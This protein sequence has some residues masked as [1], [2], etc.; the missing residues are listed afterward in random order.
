MQDVAIIGSGPAG[1]SAALYTTRAGLETIVYSGATRGGLPTTT[2]KV[3]NYLGLPG[4]EGADMAQLFL[5][6][7]EDL[8]AK[9]L[10]DVVDTIRRNE[11]GT[12]TV[13]LS[14]GNSYDFR[15]VIFAAGSVPRKLGVPGEELP[16]V[17]WCSTCDGSFFAGD[18]VA[19]VGGGESAVEEALYLSN[20]ASK[21]TVLVRGN[22]FRAN[23][24]AVEKLL[25]Q[26]NVSVRYNTSVLEIQGEDGVESLLLSDGSVLPVYGIFEAIG[27][28]PQSHVAH[29]HSEL[30]ADGYIRESRVEGFFI[31]GDIT[32][33]DYRQIAV[34]VGDGA[35]AAMD[36]I[37]WLQMR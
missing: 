7:A 5:K 17:S 20:L 18:D 37:K 22:D 32:N 29:D 14:S 13:R 19:V 23:R 11:D 1:L 15:S 2:E 27:Q 25:E 34:A 36:S 31:A 3:D 8:G 35:K 12:F 26:P 28:V 10:N 9:I 21:V 24:P 16:G 33:P 6:H 4:I 30:Y